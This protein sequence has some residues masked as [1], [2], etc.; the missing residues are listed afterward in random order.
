MLLEVLLSFAV[1]VETLLYKELL[2]FR[3]ELAQVG[4]SMVAVA[5]SVVHV[6][7]SLLAIHGL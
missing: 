3:T 5:L 2:I 1:E 4:C 6:M 7:P